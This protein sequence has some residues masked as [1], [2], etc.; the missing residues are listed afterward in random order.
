MAGEH[1]SDNRAIGG[2]GG[3]GQNGADGLGGG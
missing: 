1:V 2:Q 3:A